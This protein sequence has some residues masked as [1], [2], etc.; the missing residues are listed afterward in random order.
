[1]TWVWLMSQ[2]VCVAHCHG[3]FSLSPRANGSGTIASHG[4]CARSRTAERFKSDGAADPTD[5]AERSPSGAGMPCS[6]KA[7]I[8]WTISLEIPNLTPIGVPFPQTGDHGPLVLSAATTRS[9]IQGAQAR[10]VGAALPR[11]DAGFE[12][13]VIL[14]SGLRSQAPPAHA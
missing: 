11:W 6:S 2:S 12:P 7:V 13:S 10:W 9:R 14:G 1:M 3:V 8:Q 5:P 4:C